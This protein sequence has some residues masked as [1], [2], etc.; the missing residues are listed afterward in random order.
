M[1]KHQNR[2]PSTHALQQICQKTFRLSSRTMKYVGE[3][4]RIHVADFDFLCAVACSGPPKR[5]VAEGEGLPDVPVGLVSPFRAVDDQALRIEPPPPIPRSSCRRRGP[6]MQTSSPQNR[7]EPSSTSSGR[8]PE[9]CSRKNFRG[10]RAS[11][12]IYFGLIRLG[13]WLW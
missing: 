11:A 12:K 4:P 10:F 5:L 6:S 1:R 2:T 7:P 9:K 13:N 3:E 8:L